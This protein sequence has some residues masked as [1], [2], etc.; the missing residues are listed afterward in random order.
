MKKQESPIW[1][2]FKNVK[3]RSLKTNGSSRSQ[4]FYSWDHTHNDI[5]VFDSKGRYLRSMDPITGKMYKGPV[6]G[7]SIKFD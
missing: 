5:V 3:G 6:K 1:K 4:R 7:R 2:G